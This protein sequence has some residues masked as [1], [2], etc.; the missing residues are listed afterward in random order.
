MKAKYKSKTEKI[1]IKVSKDDIKEFGTLLRYSLENL[2]DL[3]KMFEDDE[4]T[5]EIKNIEE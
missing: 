1:T 4:T 2:I 3:F 5:V